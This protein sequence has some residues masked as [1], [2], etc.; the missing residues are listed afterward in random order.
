[1]LPSGSHIKYLFT[2]DS[3]LMYFKEIKLISI[4]WRNYELKH[5]CQ[6]QESKKNAILFLIMQYAYTDSVAR[7]KQLYIFFI[8]DS[9]DV[10][11][12]LIF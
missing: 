7:Y 12:Y 5:I 8:N 6:A 4:A 10:M 3:F 2:Y 9:I 11:W 1:M